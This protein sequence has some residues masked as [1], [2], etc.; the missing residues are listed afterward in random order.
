MSKNLNETLLLEE[1]KERY[2]SYRAYRTQY[3]NFLSFTVATYAI[4]F[5]LAIKTDSNT[6]TARLLVAAL[7]L[8]LVGGMVAAHKIG[9][10]VIEDLGDRIA[11]L[12]ES[13]TMASYR[14]TGMLEKSL[15]AGL[16][17]CYVGVAL[18]TA[19]T[20]FIIFG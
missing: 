2:A 9:R 19:L 20:L 3:L 8:I 13:L 5:T 17:A 10:R 12:E 4:V 6:K 18:T 16:I 15:V 14:T 1:W 7:L 11:W